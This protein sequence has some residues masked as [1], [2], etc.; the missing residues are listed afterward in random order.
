MFKFLVLKQR[1][2]N[3]NSLHV[4]LQNNMKHADNR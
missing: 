3:S 4:Q 2:S 1:K